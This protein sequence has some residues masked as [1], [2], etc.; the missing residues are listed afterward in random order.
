MTQEDSNHRVLIAPDTET[1]DRI[2]AYLSRIVIKS[3]YQDGVGIHYLKARGWVVSCL[4]KKTFE[5]LMASPKVIGGIRE[6]ISEDGRYYG[7]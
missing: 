6:I 1:Y 7:K 3:E 2:M 4:E 5:P